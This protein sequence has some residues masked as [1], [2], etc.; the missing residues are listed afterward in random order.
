VLIGVKLLSD[1]EAEIHHLAVAPAF[2]RGGLARGLIT[3]VVQRLDLDRLTAET[4][5]DGV[6]VYR[7]CG[8]EIRDAPP[9]FG[10]RRYV[11]ELNA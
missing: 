6:G 4:D 1:R 7:Q 2:R 8:F 5:D 11:C 9:R 10:R 3:E